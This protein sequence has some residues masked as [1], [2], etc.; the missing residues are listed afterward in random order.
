MK[1]TLIEE[2][3]KGRKKNKKGLAE[4]EVTRDAQSKLN[5]PCP[6]EPTAPN[7]LHRPG[8]PRPLLSLM[9]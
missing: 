8:M 7:V 6:R 5:G 1:R 3:M 9:A 4:E 2:N